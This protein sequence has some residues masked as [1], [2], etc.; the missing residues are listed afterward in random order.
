[1][2]F[3][4]GIHRLNNW[5]LLHFFLLHISAI[6]H[7]NVNGHVCVRSSKFWARNMLFKFLS[8]FL[9]QNLKPQTE[10]EWK[11]Q[12]HQRV[13]SIF[14]GTYFQLATIIRCVCFPPSRKK[15]ERSLYLFKEILLL[16]L[17]CGES[18]MMAFVVRM[19][20]WF[21]VL[22]VNKLLTIQCNRYALR[23]IWNVLLRWI[24]LSLKAEPHLEFSFFCIFLNHIWFQSIIVS[25]LFFKFV[26][27]FDHF[28]SVLSVRCIFPVLSLS[29]F[30]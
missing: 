14:T 13:F 29:P 28:G 21:P 18:K 16:S 1:M 5:T 26:R 24:P 9:F 27:L 8:A 10:I 19:V 11:I 6:Q 3:W 15:F 22:L 25:L 4:H 2:L 20:S 17:W 23:I 30:T 7:T 12:C